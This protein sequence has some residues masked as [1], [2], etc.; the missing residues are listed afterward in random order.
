MNNLYLAFHHIVFSWALHAG[1]NVVWLSAATYDAA[2]KARLN[3]PQLF[4]RVLGS[5]MIAAIA[6][7]TA[8]LSFLL[9]AKRSLKSPVTS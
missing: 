6:G 3:E 9:L 8:V 4:D 5:P 7:A 2:T 1:W